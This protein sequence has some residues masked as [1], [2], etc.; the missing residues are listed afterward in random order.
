MQLTCP[1]HVGPS[2]SLL[3]TRCASRG[4][5]SLSRLSFYSEKQVHPLAGDRQSFLLSAH[6]SRKKGPGTIWRFYP[7]PFLFQYSIKYPVHTCARQRPAFSVQCSQT[8]KC[9]VHTLALFRGA[10]LS[11]LSLWNGEMIL[12][13][14][15]SDLRFLS[16]GRRKCSNS[17]ECFIE[18]LLTLD[19]E[20]SSE[21]ISAAR[22]SSARAKFPVSHNSTCRLTS[23]L[24]AS[25]SMG[26]SFCLF[27]KSVQL[28]RDLQMR[29]AR[30]I[31]H[32]PV[33][34]QGSRQVVAAGRACLL[35]STVPQPYRPQCGRCLC[36]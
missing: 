10:N 14:K 1:C 7:V 20:R 16:P 12:F 28:P 25:I 36:W 4:S 30:E 33:L 17:C 27:I 35:R 9:Q 23:A 18:S 19:F 11:T 6:R 3:L 26:L 21:T 22:T 34:L 2:P 8:Q 15:C 13:C 32:W 5:P 31:T 29:K 24:F